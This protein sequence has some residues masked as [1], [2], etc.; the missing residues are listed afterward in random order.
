MKTLLVVPIAIIML[1]AFINGFHPT[2]A[3]VT[4]AL[5]TTA[6]ALGLIFLVSTVFKI[7]P[8]SFGAEQNPAAVNAMIVATGWAALWG[9]ISGFGAFTIFTDIPYIGWGLYF[10]VTFAYLMGVVESM[11]GGGGAGY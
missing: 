3:N 8:F 2:L 10:G 11:G 9:I 1:A 6:V 5:I 7:G 4:S